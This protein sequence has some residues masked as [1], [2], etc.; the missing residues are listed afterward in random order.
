MLGR[1]TVWVPTL[2][3][4]PP[5]QQGLGLAQATSPVCVRWAAS[6]VWGQPSALWRR[7][8]QGQ[9]MSLDRAVVLVEPADWEQGVGALC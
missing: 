8:P 1:E 6:V 3:P 2:Q 4:C 7:Q 9:G 5:Q